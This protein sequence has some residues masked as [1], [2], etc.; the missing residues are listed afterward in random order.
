M[1]IFDI[2]LHVALDDIHMDGYVK[3]MDRHRVEG[4]LVHGVPA[5]VP[6]GDNDAVARVVRRHKGRLYGSVH[7]DLR[8]PTKESIAVVRKYAGLGFRCVKLFPNF[9]FDPN[10]E[11]H[12]P[13][14]EEVEKLGLAALSHCGWLAPDTTNPRRRLHSLTATPFHFEVPARRHRKI[15]FIFAHFGGGATY[16]ETIVLLSRLPNCFADTC[17][18]WGKWVWQSRLPGLETLDRSKVLYGTDG[19]G[20]TYGESIRFWTQTMKSYGYR[21]ADLEGYFDAIARRV[22]NLPQ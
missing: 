6:L 7:V 11:R 12:E 13:F 19:A 2:H 9:G 21:K 4:G 5:H 10:D 16:L 3:I 18:G 15:N 22:L 17:P 20:S 8:R 1:N 14:W